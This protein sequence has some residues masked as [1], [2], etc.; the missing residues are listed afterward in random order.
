MILEQQEALSDVTTALSAEPSSAEP[1]TDWRSIWMVSA[2]AFATTMQL[3]LYFSS[4]WP[5]LQEI[6]KNATE[7]FF[8]VIMAIYSLGQALSSLVF[9]F[10]SNRIK[11]TKVPMM[12]GLTVM[13]ISNLFYGNIELLHSN[14]RW[15][16]LVARFITGCGGGIVGVIRA[17]TATASS[18]SDRSRAISINSGAFA[19]GLTFGPGIVV[20]EKQNK[21]FH[22]VPKFDKAAIIVCLFTRFIQMFVII[23]LETIGSPYSMI[24]FYWT[25]AEAVLYNSIA[26]VGC[27]L[28]GFGI[29][30][31]YIVLNLGKRVSE[32]VVCIAG[33]GLLF[34]FHLITYPWP[35]YS[36]HI[37]YKKPPFLYN[38]TWY[39]NNSADVGCDLTFDWCQTTPSVNVWLFMISNVLLIGL[40]FPLIN[41]SMSTLYSKI[42]GPRRQGTMQ[43]LFFFSG[44]MAR[45]LG[46]VFMAFVLLFL[47]VLSI[48]ST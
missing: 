35:F 16:M 15:G 45:M 31:S 11:Q 8:G 34:L 22:A 32:R 41:I 42:I 19:L 28:I 39:G 33:L 24:M 1:S 44:G 43:G 26:D 7:D 47:T 48:R 17:Y 46:P 9:G 21:W 25:R 5:F 12:T 37:A 2:I 3:S 38:G 13:F 10:W 14:R 4:L 20:K 27:S 36:G 29:Y 23:N 18:I 40:A 6:D 30:L